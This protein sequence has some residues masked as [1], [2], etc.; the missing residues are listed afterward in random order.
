MNYI[1]HCT[2]QN[3]PV[4]EE[5]VIFNKFPSS[6]SGPNDPVVCD[7]SLTSK[8]DYE[9]ELGFVV[10]KTVPRNTSVEDAKQYIGGFTVVHD[11]SARDWQMERNGGQWILGELNYQQKDKV[12]RYLLPFL[13]FL[14]V[15]D[16]P[17][18]NRKMPG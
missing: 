1:D 9:V 3:I 8:L 12:V 16:L 4:P 6:L 14:T 7:T 11:V 17:P 2:E 5:P 10:G 18:H 13:G 15:F